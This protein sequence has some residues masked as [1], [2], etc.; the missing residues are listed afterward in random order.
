MSVKK[1]A[2]FKLSQSAKR[3]IA[4]APVGKQSAQKKL[5]VEAEANASYS[6]RRSNTGA[7]SSGASEL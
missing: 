7:F 5:W 1:T 4:T 3:L 6:P 2:L